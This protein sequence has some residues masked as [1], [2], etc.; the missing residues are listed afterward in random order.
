MFVSIV[1]AMDRRALIGRGRELP[2]RLSADL[3]RFRRLTMGK[4]IIMGRKTFESIGRALDGRDNI[5][6]SRRPEFRAEG[7]T[8]VD[9]LER[10]YEAC[11][12]SEEG[13]VI[14]GAEIYRQSLPTVSR[15]YLTFI[16]HEFEG[17]T[18]FPAYEREAWCE[19]AC[20]EFAAGEG[21]LYPFRNVTLQRI[22]RT[23]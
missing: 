20:E 14:G 23:G 22:D 1:A 18:Y 7:C 13:M 21:I 10:A 8:V 17:D 5:V 6:V 11:G 16:D 9:S 2:W 12:G 4:P 19:T 3:R 15:M